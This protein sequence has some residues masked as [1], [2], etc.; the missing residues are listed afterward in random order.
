MSA[1]KLFHHHQPGDPVLK[2]VLFLCCRSDKDLVNQERSLSMSKSTGSRRE[3]CVCIRLRA[4][5]RAAG[6]LI[7]FIRKGKYQ[8]FQC[9]QSSHESV[10]YFDLNN[11]DSSQV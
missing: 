1:M 6:V 5:A 10:I 4:L 7:S 11:D 3:V 9:L 8:I 2:L